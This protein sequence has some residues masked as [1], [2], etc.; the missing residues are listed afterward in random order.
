MFIPRKIDL[1]WEIATKQNSS[2]RHVCFPPIFH[3]TFVS[4]CI[5][6]FCYTYIALCIFLYIFWYIT[7]SNYAYIKNNWSKWYVAVVMNVI[8]RHIVWRHKLTSYLLFVFSKKLDGDLVGPIMTGL[9]NSA[10]CS[11]WMLI[12]IIWLCS[13]I[14]QFSSL[15]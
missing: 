15:F 13:G 9:I 1:K 3:F 4:L 5:K 7:M 6:K 12:T 10:S 11:L 2:A 8:D 14:G